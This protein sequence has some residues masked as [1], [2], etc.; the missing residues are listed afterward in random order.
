MEAKEEFWTTFI[1]GWMAACWFVAVLTVLFGPCGTAQAGD[2][3]VDDGLGSCKPLY[4]CQEH[5]CKM[6]T[7]Q[8]PSEFPCYKRM[9]EAMRE[10]EKSLALESNQKDRK[11]PVWMIPELLKPTIWNHV[12]RTCVK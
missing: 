3:C 8:D 1:W 12:M 7:F 10:M 6:W 11:Q 5:D 2:L 9:Q 4:V